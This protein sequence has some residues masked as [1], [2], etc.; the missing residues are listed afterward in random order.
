MAQTSYGSITITET[1][2]IKTFVRYSE[3]SDGRNYVATPTSTTKYI[4]V[5]VGPDGTEANPPAYNN[6]G[7]K[8]SKY[9][10]NSIGSVETKFINW[11]TNIEGNKPTT[12]AAWQTA[13]PAY[14][15]SKP[16]YY[17]WT[18]ITYSDASPTDN[19]YLDAGVS[20]AIV[21]SAQALSIATNVVEDAQGAIAIARAQE[22]HFWFNATDIGSGV[23]LIESGAYITDIAIDTFKSGKNGGYLLAR[24]DKVE[25][26]KASAKYAV[27]D[28]T[29]LKFYTPGTTYKGI[30]VGTSGITIYKGWDVTRQENIKGIEITPLGID[31]YGGLSNTN[32]KVA[33]FGEIIVLGQNENNNV[34]TEISGID[35]SIIEKNS[36]GEDT[37]IFSLNA[38]NYIGLM[39]F[40]N[41]NLTFGDRNVIPP[42]VAYDDTSTY[43]VGKTCIYDNEE[44]VCKEQID[45]PEAFDSSKWEKVVGY[46]SSAFGSYNIAAGTHSFAEG[47]IVKAIG[48]YS[49]AEGSSSIAC[50]DYSHAEGSARANGKYSHAEGSGSIASSDYS[51]AEGNA[52][53]NGSYSHA[54]GYYTYADGEYS[55]AEG[56]RTYARGNYSHAEGY[57]TSASGIASHAEGYNT[58]AVGDYSHAMGKGTIAGNYQT[59]MGQYNAIDGSASFIIGNG[60]G[61][62]N[63]SNLFTIT[64]AGNLKIKSNN[65]WIIN[66]TDSKN[67][68]KISSDVL[69]FFMNIDN[70]STSVASFGVSARIGQIA[71]GKSRV[72]IKD[73]GI[74]FYNRA[75]NTD[76]ALAH[77][78]YGRGAS[79]SG[80]TDIAP[81]F[82]LGTSR[83]NVH[84][85]Y[86]FTAGVYNKAAGGG[87]AAIGCGLVAGAAQDDTTA[88]QVV[89]GRYNLSDSVGKYAFIVGNGTNEPAGES[90]AL[91]V[92]W[93]GNVDIAS[94]AKYK[95]N[96][97]AHT[98]PYS[99]LTGVASSSHTHTTLTHSS[100]S[101]VTVTSGSFNLNKRTT[102][103]TW[104]I[105]CPSKT[106][107]SPRCIVGY[108]IGGTYCSCI[109]VFNMYVDQSEDKVHVGVRNVDTALDATDITV[110][111]FILY[112][113]DS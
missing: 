36:L 107:Y 106:N 1:T 26:G 103:A 13:P 87:T 76:V 41:P 48:N 10:G 60:S 53:A 94:G 34:R 109:N 99:E 24:S 110:T 23:N 64:N 49:H 92:D 32:K 28:A 52:R 29:S 86:S 56:Y 85:N 81:Y 50:G 30:E 58:S 22:Q 45:T 11:A 98:H 47:S 104:T 113:R 100:I 8:W 69:E 59:A 83:D 72:E 68:L 12:S 38:G 27:L 112:T 54:E 9:Q 89:I 46:Y 14:D 39:A 21:K 65:I 5:Y 18:R 78:G 25:M 6:S 19:I 55:H 111:L 20:E 102:K 43:L 66:G 71:N 16:Y 4:G 90:N 35:F 37:K 97:S 57:D 88:G 80:G 51:H 2:D 105:N 67:Y 93:R 74:D 77:I 95:I 62:S 96:G 73:T 84:G 63:R 91:T 61:D 33:S 75:Y 7:W 108:T 44:Y 15:A 40:L 70:V 101:I 79:Q 17:V 3:N 42:S 82:I 31:I